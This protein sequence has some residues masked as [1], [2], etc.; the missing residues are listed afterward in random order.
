MVHT[1]R[2]ERS[3]GPT[4]KARKSSEPLSSTRDNLAVMAAAD[5]VVSPGEPARHGFALGMVR[6]EN[7]VRGRG[8]FRV[9]W[10]LR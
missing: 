5:D 4:R 1:A 2:Q 8:R 10:A 9:C 7:S 6:G 3:C